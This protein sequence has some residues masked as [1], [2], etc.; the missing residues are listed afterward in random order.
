MCTNVC[1]PNT[2]QPNYIT[3]HYKVEHTLFL[4][5]MIFHPNELIFHPNGLIFHPNNISPK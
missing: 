4:L 5:R 3:S 2:I 1:T